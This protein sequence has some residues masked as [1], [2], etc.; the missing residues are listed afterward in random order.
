[1]CSTVDCQLLI[2]NSST[3]FKETPVFLLSYYFFINNIRSFFD[4]HQHSPSLPLSTAGLCTL[5]SFVPKAPLTLHGSYYLIHETVL[6]RKLLYTPPSPSH[7][8]HTATIKTSTSPDPT[9][10]STCTNPRTTTGGM[11]LLPLFWSIKSSQQCCTVAWSALTNLQVSFSHFGALDFG[12][13]P[14]NYDS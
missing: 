12:P 2:I 4:L 5:T 9:S 11:T 7:H 13:R 10:S 1:M 6:D 8:H 14:N 3:H